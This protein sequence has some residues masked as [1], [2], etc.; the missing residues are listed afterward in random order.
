MGS[1]VVLIL[2]DQADQVFC[3]LDKILVAVF[4]FLF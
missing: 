3:S 2:S 1:Q 4:T